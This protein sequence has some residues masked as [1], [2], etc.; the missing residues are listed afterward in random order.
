MN[1]ANSRSLAKVLK[2]HVWLDKKNKAVIQDE[3]QPFETDIEDL[4][5]KGEMVVN[6]EVKLD[7]Y[8]VAE[9]VE[10]AND[11]N[12]DDIFLS[13]AEALLMS[14]TDEFDSPDVR[15]NTWTY[16]SDVTMSYVKDNLE[17]VK[18]VPKRGR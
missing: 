16:N 1:M 10:N 11:N 5:L 17:V 8:E 14:V 4:V 3:F 9:F 18:V 12:E 13:G 7:G 6:F 2:K 15:L